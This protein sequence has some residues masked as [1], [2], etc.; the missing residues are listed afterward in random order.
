MPWMACLP[1]VPPDRTGEASGST[2]MICI[3]GLYRKS[4]SATPLNVPPVPTAATKMSTSPS[5]SVQISSPVVFACMAGFAGFS[6][7]PNMMELGVVAFSRS[8]SRMAPDIPSAPEVSTIVAPNVARSRRR[9]MLIV[10]GIVKIRRY[11]FIAA[12]QAK[13][14]PVLP[15]VGSISVAPQVILPSFSAASIMAKAV[16]SFTLPPGLNDSAFAT[17]R[18]ARFS[19]F[20]KCESSISGVLPTRSSIVL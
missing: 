20:S 4:V 7:W 3:E 2:A 19:V 12:A 18:A 9:S 13:P 8:A 5:V 11:P 14:T 15:L 17:M 16:R 10:S 1:A 6:N